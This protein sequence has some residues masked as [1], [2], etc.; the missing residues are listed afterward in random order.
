MTMGKLID[1]VNAGDCKFKFV[2]D[3]ATFTGLRKCSFTPKELR[4]DA[5]GLVKEK[6]AR[7][8]KRV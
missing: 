6:G 1:K 8:F 7:N 4:S 5:F 2:K 3:G